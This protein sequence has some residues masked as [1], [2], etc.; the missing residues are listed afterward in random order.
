M[1]WTICGAGR[2]VGKTTVAMLIADILDSSIYCKCG[3]NPPKPEK[4]GNFFSGIDALLDFVDDA[5]DRYDHI[6]VESN[7]FV[8]SDRTDITIYID[9]VKGKTDF[10]EDADRLKA[11]ADIVITADSSPAQWK[12]LLS[13]KLSD[14]KTIEALCRSLTNQQQWLY[15]GENTNV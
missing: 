9:G 5:A 3:H 6:I 10:R 1:I 13:K 8:Y 12:T 11:A 14:T 4:P 2:Q 7:T 15:F